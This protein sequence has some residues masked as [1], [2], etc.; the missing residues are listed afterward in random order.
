MSA[1]ARIDL[2]LLKYLWSG[3]RKI[4]VQCNRSLVHLLS[5]RFPLLYLRELTGLQDIDF[6]DV[7]NA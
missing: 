3:H 7:S 6:N 2:I 4:E 5:A 1:L